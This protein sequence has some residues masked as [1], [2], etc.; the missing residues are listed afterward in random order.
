MADNPQSLQAQLD[1]K[2]MT[3][4]QWR[5][6]VLCWL[7][8]ILD[9]F[10]LLA[11]SFAAPAIAK[12]WALDPQTL[13]IVFSCGLLGMT[14]GSLLLGPAADRIGR[15]RMILL[16]TTIL[17]LSTLATAGATSV[18][19]LLLLRGMTGIAIGALLPSLNTLVAEY[20]PDRRRNL[21]ISFMHLGY[22]IGGIAGG[23]LASYII[24]SAGWQALFLSGGIFTLAILP[25]LLFG[26]P[27]SLHY[28]LQK[29][30]PA[31][32]AMTGKLAIRL[33]IDL[34][35]AQ[36]QRVTTSAARFKDVLRGQWLMPGLALWACFFLGN[37]TLYFLLNWTPTVL[38]GAG[39]PHEQ[40]MRAGMLLNLGGGIGML[41]LGYLSARWSIYRMMSGYFILGGL[42]IMALGQ[43]PKAD[44]LFGLTILAG[45]FAL[46]GLIGLYSLAARL[47]PDAT[48]ATGIG[49]AIGAGRFGAILGPYAGGVLISMGWPM[50]SYFALLALPLIAV[51]V[52]LWRVRRPDGLA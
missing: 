11:I 15:R 9:G 41:S 7:V 42:F 16:A 35:A 5:V 8:N 31:A 17:G 27:E 40:A 45:F 20:T 49:L 39:L 1:A 3:S 48:R 26:L 6:V 33:G 32:Q 50:G 24:P 29:N 51:A 38:I 44:M 46:G 13:G 28:L 4:L 34:H 21:A 30:Q 12:T 37:L 22:P 2:P 52:I 10:D 18:G 19:Q 43:V 47:Y 23:L 36:A 25:V 14:A